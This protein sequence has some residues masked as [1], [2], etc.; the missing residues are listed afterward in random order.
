[1]APEISGLAKKKQRKKSP[2]LLPPRSPP[3]STKFIDPLLPPAC[4]FFA[5]LFAIRRSGD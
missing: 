5:D 3:L 4:R 1:M 2:S